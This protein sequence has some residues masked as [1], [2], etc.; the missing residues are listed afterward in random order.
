[1]ADVDD[2]LLEALNKFTF[3]PKLPKELRL[4]IVE[5]AIAD[6]DSKTFVVSF[7]PKH[8]ISG[9]G[10][11]TNRIRSGKFSITTFH[12]PPLLQANQD[13]RKAALK[14]YKL[15]FSGPLNNRP[16]YFD[17]SK[18][19]LAFVSHD[20]LLNMKAASS[21][22]A[23]K[24]I[25]SQLRYLIVGEEF[26]NGGNSAVLN[27][28]ATFHKLKAFAHQDQENLHIQWLSNN[29]ANQRLKLVLEG[30]WNKSHEYEELVAKVER[31]AKLIPGP[32][33]K[34]VYFLPK[35][36]VLRIEDMKGVLKGNRMGF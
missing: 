31:E 19:K 29:Q 18:D 24:K 16:V 4:Q 12:V 14:T 32:V 34:K 26:Y 7:A 21:C 20:A 1:M 36:E 27:T 10:T 17:F 15:S 25:E 33:A 5:I 9:H 30:N 23:W 13:I 22:S 2:N 8:M 3:Y 35:I 11:I 6:A 28:I